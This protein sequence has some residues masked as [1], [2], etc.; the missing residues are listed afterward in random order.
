MK[1]VIIVA[2][3]GL[4]CASPA[5]ACEWHDAHAAATTQQLAMTDQKSAQASEATPDQRAEQRRLLDEP[6]PGP[7]PTA[8]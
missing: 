5:L 8:D 7:S 4:L 2:G 3:L 1:A 6:R